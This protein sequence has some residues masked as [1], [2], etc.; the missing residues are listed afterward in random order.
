MRS[1]SKIS[2]MPVLQPGRVSKVGK[3]AALL[4]RLAALLVFCSL[5]ALLNCGGG[6]GGSSHGNGGGGQSG[7]PAL[8]AAVVT[9]GNLSSGQS[10]ASY[11]ITVSNTGNGATSGTVTVVGPPTGFTVTAISG[12]GWTCTLSSTTCTRS[13]SLAAGASFP[14]ITV[15]GNVTSA[16]GTPVTIPLTLSGGGTSSS[17][18]VTPTPTVTVTAPVLSVTKTHTGNFN[19]G[20]QGA[21]YSVTVKNGASAGATNAKVT[22]TETVP[23]GETLV[24]MSGNGWTCPGTGGANTCDRSDTLAT[25]AS[26]PA[27]TVTVNVA[28][29]ATSP[30]VNHVSVSG[31]GMSSSAS[32]ND[33]TTINLAPDLAIVTSHSSGN[34]GAGNNNVFTLAVSNVGS[35]PTTGSITVSDTLDANFTFVSATASG[36]TCG[37]VSQVVTCTNPGP[38]APG[39][40][41]MSI[42][43]VVAVSA[44][45]SGTINNTGTPGHA[46]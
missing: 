36:W 35:G 4:Q 8:T 42:P 21:T 27:V 20:Q 12:T 33:S 29:N 26:Y 25:G 10:N 6:G 28:A 9:Q 39:A 2:L 24:S 34:F 19:S 32:A 31:G 11:T 17:V 16:N 41:A 13:D 22:L 15:T 7:T 23:S 38:L 1:L 45:A 43:L 3:T 18:T 30:Q 40:S 46:W 14:T 37:A 5:S 44:S